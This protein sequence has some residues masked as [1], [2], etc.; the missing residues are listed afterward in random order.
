MSVMLLVLRQFFK[1]AQMKNVNGGEQREKRLMQQVKEEGR[2]TWCRKYLMLRELRGGRGEVYEALSER[3]PAP[4]RLQ[5]LG[6]E[7]G[8]LMLSRVSEMMCP[9]LMMYWHL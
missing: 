4:Q 3:N 7:T 9:C 8:S 1:L 2:R 6:V 5:G